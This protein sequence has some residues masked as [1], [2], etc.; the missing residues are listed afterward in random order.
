MKLTLRL[1]I[2]KSKINK[3]R[4]SIIKCRIT[5][6]KERKEFSTGIFINSIFWDSQH[7]VAKPP[8]DEND[9]I[10]TQLS[11]IKSKIN[12]AFLLLQV[13]EGNFT[14][15]DIHML[16]KGKKPTKEHNV[17]EQFESHLNML[18]KLVG[19]DIKQA[20][21]NKLYYVKNNV[22]SFI[23]WK[24]KTNDLPLK[25]LKLQFLVDFEYYLKV[26]KKQK[27]ITINKT[28]QRFRNPIKVALSKGYL[29]RD[30]FMLYKAKK[31]KTEIV[32]L[33]VD[34]LKQFESFEFKQT[35]LT[36][37]KDWFVFSC[38]TGLAYNEISKLQKKHISKGFDGEF[39]IEVVREKTQ[40]NIAVPILPKAQQLID[41]YADANSGFIFKI[42]S[43]QRYN[44]YLKE[45]ASI[46]GIDK[47][48]TTHTAR[49]TFAST[50]LLYNDVPM[51]I[52][53]QLL[54]HS[55]ITITEDSYGKIVQKKVSEEMIRLTKNL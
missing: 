15:D 41:K 30:P 3:K 51:E 32:F 17:V 21:W 34:E 14:V 29:E 7:Q 26:E 6:K 13:Q 27:Q 39:W 42:C 44:S 4:N 1:F 38:Y 43:N 25:S 8:N 40:K 50:V 22:K 20:T 31:V 55:S 19:I 10:N 16:Y 45:I 18:K 23:R 54:G 2:E 36:Q 52:V 48:L 28:I 24:F 47:R 46:L 9:Y 53:S 37:V 12:R 5:Y 11:L 49:K 33:S 35:R